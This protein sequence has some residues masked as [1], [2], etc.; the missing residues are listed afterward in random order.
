V[1]R[2]LVLVFLLAGFGWP[3]RAN[4]AP[5]A[6]ANGK[7]RVIRAL[8]ISGTIHVDGILDEADWNKADVADD[9][10][11]Y[12]PDEGAPATERTEVRVLYDQR[13]LYIGVQCYDSRPDL[14]VA[15]K[16]QRDSGVQ[17]DD[18]FRMTLDTFH[19]NRTG[20]YFATNPN[21][22]QEDGQV[23]DGD[24]R[25]NRDWNGVW[26]VRARINDKGWTAEFWIPFWTLRFR[27]AAEQTWGINFQRIIKRK[28]EEVNWA[29]WSRDNGGFL[30]LSR[31]GELVGLAGVKQGTNLQLKPYGISRSTRDFTSQPT[32]ARETADAGMDLK[33]SLTPGLTLDLT[34]NT[35]FAQ[36]EADVQQVNLTRFS[37]FF[38]EKRDFF[39][40][41]ASLFEF[42]K[43]GFRGPEMLLFFS[44]RIGLEGGREVPILGG[45]QLTGKV[46]ALN[47]GALDIVTRETDDIPQAHFSVLRVKRDIFQRSSI[48]AIFTNRVDRGV[49]E[50]RAVG[51]DADVWL[52][53]RFRTSWFYAQNLTPGTG[54][55]QHAALLRLD[56]T[57]DL[58]GWFAEQLVIGDGFN[59]RIG[60]VPRDNMRRTNVAFR[61]SRQPNGRVFR[62][63]NMFNSVTYITDIHGRL[64]DRD[65]AV[66]F[67]NDFD[68]GDRMR[69]RF[70]RSFRRLDQVFELRENLP[71]P[72]GD[73]EFNELDA[74]FDSS[75]KRR[76]IARAGV[77]FGGFY[78]GRRRRLQ[79]RLGY[80]VSPHF[81]FD[82]N[83]E[84]N[85]V[86]LP[87]GD[88]TTNLTT[89]RVN[90]LFNTRLF[91]NA[92][93]QYNSETDRL[94]SN[95]R[96]NFR[97]SPGSDIFLVVNESRDTASGQY[98]ARDR[99]VALKLT[100]L[101][102]F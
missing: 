16:L 80:I 64:Q 44:R 77:R 29:S 91:V 1:R 2:W 96:L 4:G 51:V 93:I 25:P 63:I 102:H 56:Y 94:S 69:L 52:T 35:D 14:I 53:N 3:I 23:R 33:Y 40:E 82:A 92:L 83:Y 75:P 76:W 61:I 7:A 101:F 21:G 32:L 62:R 10:R 68:S 87:A 65:L 79:M 49:G 42:G 19:D 20:F 88:L 37:L 41:K 50:N 26:Q 73:Y 11:Q 57:S 71:I 95:I 34:Y 66:T 5:G 17:D 90:V 78:S 46:G 6:A 43:R 8:R 22:V 58:F 85:R 18:A 84:R 45:G 48:G 13:G 9:F 60:F 100:K 98:P 36:V 81:S 31:A 55:R 12:Q 24:R 59:P 89:L 27:D 38:P 30:R 99:A 72:V 74:S 47:V 15:Q 39:L 97:Y 54:Q 70:Q 28:N 67:F 86:E